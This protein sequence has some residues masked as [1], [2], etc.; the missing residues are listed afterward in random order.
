LT[1]LLSRVSFT[2]IEG[3]VSRRAELLH[4][5]RIQVTKN[6]KRTGF[7]HYA[8][9]I[10]LAV[11]VCLASFTIAL[12]QKPTTPEAEPKKE[13]KPGAKLPFELTVKTRPILNIS[14]KAEKAKMPEVAQ[15]LSKRLKTPIFLGPERQHELLTVEF[16]QLTLEPAL[17]LLSPTVYVDYEINTGSTEQPKPLGIYFYDANQGEPPLTAVV[18]GSTQSML[19]EGNTEDGV[20]TETDDAEKKAEEQPL[21][22][23]FEKNLLTVK[24]K[25]QPLSVVLLKI[26]EQIGIPVDIQEQGN[27][28]VDTEISKLPIEDV[29]RQL[30]PNIRLFLR[31]DLTRAERRALRLVLAEP[32]KTTQQNP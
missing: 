18:N 5:Q 1:D 14:L 30:S 19:I 2:C 29:V 27:L 16:S 31:A 3:A 13:S 20:E 10:T 25:K 12:S 6:L 26:G 8:K 23:V 4:T 21:R 32:L 15:E 11:L 17:Q 28:L 24:A 9:G 22:I 7:Y